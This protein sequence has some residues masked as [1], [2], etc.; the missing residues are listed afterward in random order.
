MPLLDKDT[1]EFIS[2]KPEQ[3]RRLGAR[4][5]RLLQGG[6]VIALEGGLGAGKTAFAQGMGIGWGASAPLISPTFILVRRHERAHDESFLYH[7]DLYRLNSVE[8]A[9]ELGLEELLGAP[10]AVCVVEWADRAPELFPEEH[11][12]ITLRWID[13][14]QRGLT[15]RARGQRHQALLKE[16][17]EVI[18]GG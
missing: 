4:L 3:T 7:I 12:W 13:D 5:G 6:D 11:L 16:Y 18:I 15:I 1:L 17:R 8:A 10:H 2:R 9:E 14:L